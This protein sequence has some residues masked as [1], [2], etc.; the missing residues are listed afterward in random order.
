MVLSL[1]KIPQYKENQETNIEQITT[2]VVPTSTKIK[3]FAALT[4]LIVTLGAVDHYFGKLTNQNNTPQTT[5]TLPLSELESKHLLPDLKYTRVIYDSPELGKKI[6]LVT[7]RV[8]VD[9]SYWIF[10]KRSAH[11]YINDNESQWFIS[12]ARWE[13]G[14]DPL[15]L[16][17][18]F[19]AKRMSVERKKNFSRS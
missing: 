11:F 16:P 6:P 1:E 9:R 8:T 14:K 13:Q 10:G 17:I 4:T 12:G 2:E 7:S 18:H 15:K 19:D 3:R 5:Y